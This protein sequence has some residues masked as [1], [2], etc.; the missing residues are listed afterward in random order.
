MKS[1]LCGLIALVAYLSFSGCA[2]FQDVAHDTAK[3]RRARQEFNACAGAEDQDKHYRD[4][5]QAGYL[6]VANG[7]G[8]KTR[9]FAPSK[10]FSP[11]YQNPAG[12][13]HL[14]NWNCGYE[15]GVEYAM[16]T[17]AARYQ[18]VPTSASLPKNDPVMPDW[19]FANIQGTENSASHSDAEDVIK[20]IDVAP[21]HDSAKEKSEESKSVSPELP[22]P[23]ASKVAP[24][25]NPS[26]QVFR[27]DA[28]SGKLFPHNTAGPDASTQE[29]LPQRI[30]VAETKPVPTAPLKIESERISV[31]Q[32]LPVN[33]SPIKNTPSESAASPTIAVPTAPR[34]TVAS[35]HV[36]NVPIENVAVPA[37]TK[38]K[39]L[40]ETIPAQTV[41]IERVAM[42]ALRKQT[43]PSE[44]I[45]AQ[46]VP[47]E[48]VPIETVP[49]E[50]V[51]VETVPVET[52]PVETVP[53]ETV[54][55]EKVPIETVPIETVSVQT[56]PISTSTFPGKTQPARLNLSPTDVLTANDYPEDMVLHLLPC[57]SLPNSAL[58][59]AAGHVTPA[60]LEKDSFD[61]FPTSFNMGE[62]I[63]SISGNSPST[64]A[65]RVT[66]QEPQLQPQSSRRVAR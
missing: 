52:V 61:L 19:Y 7:S 60:T 62:T 3:K 10:Y 26:A 4:G 22:K 63:L 58:D 45:P 5:W 11:R 8:G 59:K 9:P 64:G 56:V 12:E 65:A 13:Q 42:P 47:I 37:A 14:A 29:S 36:E 31:A 2:S 51:P 46:T 6:D 53:V 40:G 28:E 34:Q 23:D 32:N 55:V 39:V 44:S 21:V 1:K 35:I 17:D 18:F 30:E 27:F 43:V 66:N 41:P 54:P 15:A 16:A 25:A 20:P 48:T 24:A 49:V 57:G 38:P 33:S 50:T